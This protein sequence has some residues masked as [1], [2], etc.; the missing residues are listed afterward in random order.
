MKHAK[1]AALGILLLIVFG[2]YTY[3]T[4]S[5]Q[6]SAAEK[7]TIAMVTFPG[8]APLYVADELNLWGADIDVEIV[9]IESIGDMRAALNS[10]NIDMYAA[11]Y[12]IFQAVEGTVPEGVAF[13]AIDKS[14]GGDGVVVQDGIN[15]LSDLKGKKV[16]AEPGFP[17]FFVLQYLLNEEGLT[18]DDVE[19]LDV[20]SQDAGTAFVAG[21]VDVAATY[22]PYL[23]I[24]KDKVEGA[25]ILASSA[26]TPNL[27]VDFLF[28]SEEAMSEKSEA[29]SA[30]ARGWFA[31]VDYIEEG[32]NDAYD[33][34]GEAFGT[35]AAEIRDF[36][37]GLSWLD[38]SDNDAL[39]DATKANNAYDTFTL[40]G[41]ILESNGWTDVRLDA[42][43][44]LSTRILET[45]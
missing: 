13:L 9:R 12:D 17:P 16:A 39:F 19:L 8:Y 3:A 38:R 30:V 36:E 22:E 27:I 6:S 18:L 7:V 2:A 23:S 40:V 20:T 32:D 45:L 10:G 14:N 15:S 44:H 21:Q 28:A 41:D 29:L 33:I 11:T 1:L 24:S 5:N 25:T 26:D 31:A 34:M 4:L 42:Q 35:D 43:E 37:L